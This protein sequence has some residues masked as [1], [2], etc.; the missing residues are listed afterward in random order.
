MKIYK[1]RIIENNGLYQPQVKRKD[2]FY[3]IRHWRPL[4]MLIINSKT[5]IDH[6]FWT[7]HRINAEN[8]LNEFEIT[9]KSKLIY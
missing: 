1:A 4:S 7:T 6:S 3:K 8:K 9:T 5:D 2:I